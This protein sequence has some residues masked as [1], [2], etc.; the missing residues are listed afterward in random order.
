[1]TGKDLIQL[2]FSPG[3]AVGAVELLPAGI[4]EVPGAYKD[5]HSV[6]AAQADLVEVIARFDPKIV[7]MADAGEKPE[8]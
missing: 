6:M 1:M 2:G 3:P 5:I 4:D 8:D 7:R